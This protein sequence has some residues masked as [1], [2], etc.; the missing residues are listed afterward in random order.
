MSP[1]QYALR[2]IKSHICSPLYCYPQVLRVQ[3]AN[4]CWT[5]QVC[6]SSLRC[7]LE[8]TLGSIMSSGQCATI[9]PAAVVPEAWACTDDDA[10]EKDALDE[11]HSR[12]DDIFDFVSRVLTSI[13]RSSTL[14]HS[15]TTNWSITHISSVSSQ[16]W[17]LLLDL[18]EKVW[19]LCYIVK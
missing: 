6:K 19:H 10:C 1:L 13:I 16:R 11:S 8:I 2:W 15:Y 7:K 4:R 9:L 14:T 3:G 17:R 12:Y 18:N 5:L